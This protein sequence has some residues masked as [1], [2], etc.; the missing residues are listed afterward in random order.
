MAYKRQSPG[1][2]VEGYTNA[3]T[4][5][6]AHG[7]SYYD[8]TRVVV[9]ATGN[10]L[11]VLKSNGAGVAPTYQTTAGGS[12]ISIIGFTDQ[13]QISPN[14]YLATTASD[15]YL[16]SFG[17][18]NP[19]KDGASSNFGICPLSGTFSNMYVYIA[20]NLSTTDVT[21]TLVV[22]G[23]TTA[24]LVTVTAATTGSFSNTV[25]TAAITAGQSVQMLCQQA[26]TGNVFGSISMQFS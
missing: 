14:R 25:D 22:N 3:T 21:F 15:S 16:G 17:F 23:S 7:T 2:I 5:A 10:A 12:G 9:T 19:G 24:L 8:G 1:P 20:E 26:T 6:T 4:M 13:N 11:D 18:R